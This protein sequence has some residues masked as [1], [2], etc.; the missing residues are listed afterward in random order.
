MIIEAEKGVSLHKAAEDLKD[1]LSEQNS[2][3]DL[4]FNDINIRVTKNSNTY[5][6]LTIYDLKQTINRMKAGYKD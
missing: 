4:R 2:Y 6:L 5:D 1:S 3:L